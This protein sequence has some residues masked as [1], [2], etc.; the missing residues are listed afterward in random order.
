MQLKKD[1]VNTMLPPT[2]NKLLVKIINEQNDLKT[3]DNPFN[4]FF[5]TIG[6]KL[7]DNLDNEIQ[8]LSKLLIQPRFLIY[9]SKAT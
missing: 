9:L 5:S 3:V 6:K 4:T 1:L 8:Y 2:T 7:A